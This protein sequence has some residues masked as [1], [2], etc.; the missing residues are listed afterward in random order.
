MDDVERKL[1]DLGERTARDAAYRAAPAARIVR[2]ARVRRALYVGAPVLAVVLSAAVALPRI[3]WPDDR[4]DTS[5][6][7]LTG[8][9]DATED[10]GTARIE[11]ELE[12]R[13]GSEVMTSRSSGVIDFE[14]GRAHLQVTYTDD[15][16]ESV[17]EVVT[18]GTTTFERPA[19]SPDAK[20]SIV[21]PPPGATSGP[22]DS[23]PAEFLRYVESVATEVTRV[24][25]EVRDGVSVTRY[26]AV[27]DPAK[28]AAASG[29]EL[30]EGLE[31]ENDPMKLWVDEQGRVRETE[32]GAT[33]T[34]D[35]FSQT[36][37]GSTR[38]FDFGTPVDIEL[39][40]PDEITE[41]PPVDTDL[42]TS[43]EPAP[44]LTDSDFM[45]GAGGLREPH[46]IVDGFD[47]PTPLVCVDTLEDD[48]LSAL[49]ED[50][51]GQ[52]VLELGRAD[53]KRSE[54]R[55]GEGVACVETT[56]DYLSLSEPEQYVLTV[57]WK[58][59][60][61]VVPLEM[62]MAPMDPTEGED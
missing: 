23:R 3:G 2:R 51:S 20:W 42:F 44:E 38:F 13:V 54:V 22:P 36:M 35:D 5:V 39:P 21:D 33:T 6:A 47:R 32:F 1:R 30:P 15:G 34:L 60:R 10:Q 45:V 7:L 19:G 37:R 46:V 58:G 49:L 11:T 59:G 29:Q 62:T 27:L 9:V 40:G 8:A 14:T 43:E 18:D 48:P 52:T 53:F 12:F 17:L 31:I 61:A 55:F 24:G 26:Q 4:P 25:V 41:N 57:E 56:H 28:V 16:Q 50:R